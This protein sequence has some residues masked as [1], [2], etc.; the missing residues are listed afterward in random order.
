MASRCSA[1]EAAAAVLGKGPVS[2][3][4]QP[5]YAGPDRWLEIHD[6]PEVIRQNSQQL[7]DE[8]TRSFHGQL[9]RQGE[10]VQL[11]AFR[12]QKV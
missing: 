5:Q 1:E 4:R 2:A 12:P 6:L 11:F 9:R 10:R 8:L 7:L 3:A